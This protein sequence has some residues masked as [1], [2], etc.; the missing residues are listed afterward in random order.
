MEPEDYKVSQSKPR[1]KKEA[2]MTTTTMSPNEQ[3]TLVLDD[4][5]VPRRLKLSAL[6]VATMFL[7]VY[8]DMF[9]LY[10]PGTI[11]EIR[12]GRVWEFTISQTWALGALVLMAIPSL[13]I[14]LTLTLPKRA[15]RWTNLIVAALLVV[16]S[17]GNAVGESWS[18]YWLGAA[19]ET[20]LL[21]A[22]IRIGW[23]WQR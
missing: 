16:V 19:L 5:P 14:A 1:A 23:R 13:M 18:F 15:A 12:A 7:Y 8:V 17:V 22:V 3:A 21:V 20:A 4:A 9:S 11:D 6:W 10:T 2:L